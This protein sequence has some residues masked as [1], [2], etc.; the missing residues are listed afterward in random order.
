ML[1]YLLIVAKHIKAPVTL[2]IK[3]VGSQPMPMF[4][5]QLPQIVPGHSLG[6]PR[7]NSSLSFLQLSADNHITRCIFTTFPFILHIYFAV[8]SYSA[9]HDN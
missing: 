3:R 2:W 5:S 8:N 6:T 7:I 4:V 1:P 9:S